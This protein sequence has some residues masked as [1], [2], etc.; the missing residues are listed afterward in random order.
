MNRLGIIMNEQEN[1]TSS[2]NPNPQCLPAKPDF[3]AVYMEA[4]RTLE[5]VI[6]ANPETL[7]KDLSSALEVGNAL[8]QLLEALA[9]YGRGLQCN[10]DSLV[11]HLPDT[12]FPEAASLKALAIQLHTAFHEESRFCANMERMVRARILESAGIDPNDN[13]AVVKFFTNVGQ[14][15]MMAP[16]NKDN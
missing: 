2:N 9:L 12:A 5:A 4:L 11:A 7:S 10:L 8:F 1:N 15:V 6:A 16:A 3:S 14:A 13:D